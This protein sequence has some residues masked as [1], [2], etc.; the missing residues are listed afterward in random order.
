M[1]HSRVRDHLLSRVYV[2]LIG[3]HQAD[4]RWQVVILW[5][6]SWNRRL[7]CM[8]ST[9]TASLPVLTEVWILQCSCGS[10]GMTSCV[11][12][13]SIKMTNVITTSYEHRPALDSTTGHR[14]QETT[15]LTTESLQHRRCCKHTQQVSDWVTT[16]TGRWCGSASLSCH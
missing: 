5:N 6:Y 13:A 3:L 7:L 16:I 10:E 8:W 1:K 4:N 11:P 15:V 14:F 9:C 2:W 12:C